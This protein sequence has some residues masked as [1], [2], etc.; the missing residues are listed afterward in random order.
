MTKNGKVISIINMKGGVGKTTLT[1]GLATFFAEVQKKKVLVID[2]DPQSNATQSLMNYYGSNKKQLQKFHSEIKKRWKEDMSDGEETPFDRYFYEEYILKGAKNILNLFPTPTARA[3]SPEPINSDTIT[4]LSENLSIIAGNLDLV[5]VQGNNNKKIR[6][7]LR[8]QNSR[9]SFDYIFIDCPPTLTTYTDACLIASDY[10]L[11]P[12]HLEYYSI[13]G[14]NSLMEVIDKLIR[15]EELN[16]KCLG[17]VYSR[18]P[19]TLPIKTQKIKDAFEEKNRE[20]RNI[21][22]FESQMFRNSNLEN[23]AKGNIAIEYLE[24]KDSIGA[25]AIE[26]EGKINKELTND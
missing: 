23:G 15:D 14:I 5:Y 16:L 10:Y 12:N 11:V 22:I 21:S 13:L 6:T 4:Q 19:K 8:E 26:L 7:F 20:K 25:I 18:I 17:V 24:S 2:G 3:S 9:E 1:I